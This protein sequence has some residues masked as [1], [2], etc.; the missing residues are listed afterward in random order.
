MILTH[1]SI[2][3]LSIQSEDAKI[4]CLHD[5][6]KALIKKFMLFL[7]PASEVKPHTGNLTHVTYKKRTTQLPDDDLNIGNEAR[8]FLIEHEDDFDESSVS[9]SFFW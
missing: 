6:M 9:S 4:V 5:D 7:L 2:F 8:M 1:N 3:I